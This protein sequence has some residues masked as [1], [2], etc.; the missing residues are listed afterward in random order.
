[1]TSTIGYLYPYRV[2]SAPKLWRA[3]IFNVNQFNSAFSF[4]LQQA[5]TFDNS[6]IFGTPSIC[7][8]QAQAQRNLPHGNMIPHIYNTVPVHNTKP[9]IVS[10][11]RQ[12][13]PTSLAAATAI[14]AYRHS[15]CRSPHNSDCRDSHRIVTPSSLSTT[16]AITVVVPW[17]WKCDHPI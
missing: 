4:L 7:Q 17:P 11:Y 16:I 1:M 6:N 3:K 8:R 13:H 12:L 9:S 15:H 10:S 2:S 5:V 14:D